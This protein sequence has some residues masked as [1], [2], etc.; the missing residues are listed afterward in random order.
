MTVHGPVMNTLSARLSASPALARV[1][2]FAVFL[3]LTFAQGSLGES[4]RYWIYAAKTVVGAWLIWMVWPLV[5]EMRWKFSAV[6]VLAGVGVFA[7]W[8]GLD[9]F[10]PGQQ[11]L[12]VQLGLSKSPATP[13]APWNPLA[14]FSDA[15]VLG[16]FFVAIRIL[17]SAIVVPPIEEAFYRSFLYRWIA[18]PDF[19]S[20][21]LGT[22]AFKPFLLT[23]LIFGFAHNEWLAGILCAAAYQGLVCWKKNLGEAMAAHAITNLLLGLY[24]VGRGQW[25]FW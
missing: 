7:L 16:W 23:A 11:E 6:A 25:Q 13:T 5:T 1:L 18:S 24:I 4:S 19:Q 8:V 21:A 17:G 22:F 15:A 2:P 14:H 3:L 12:W 20:Q 9:R 10:V